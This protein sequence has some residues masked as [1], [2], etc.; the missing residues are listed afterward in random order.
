M[1][2]QITPTV[3]FRLSAY[4]FWLSAILWLIAGVRRGSLSGSIPFTVF[5]LIM[6]ALVF[7]FSRHK[8]SDSTS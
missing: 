2:T 5:F 6:G 3:I 8:S 4:L 7:L 1:Q